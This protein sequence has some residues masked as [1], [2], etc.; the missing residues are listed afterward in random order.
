MVIKG[1]Q[2]EIHAGLGSK[3]GNL[4]FPTIHGIVYSG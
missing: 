4:E 3:I 1:S 2:L